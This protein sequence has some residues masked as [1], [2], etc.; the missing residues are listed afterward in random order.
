[1][2]P[3]SEA[4]RIL[5][6]GVLQVVHAVLTAVTVVLLARLLS[7]EVFGLYVYY[8]TLAALLPLLMGMG[9]EHVLVMHGSRS[10]S[11]VPLLFG[12]ALLVR[13][14]AMAITVVG[15]LLYIF[16][17]ASTHAFAIALIFVGGAL[18]VFPNPLF[19]SV[20][21]V[22]G[23]HVRPWLLNLT[24]SGGFVLYLILLP[25]SMMSLTSV[26]V[27]YCLVQG[28]SAIVLY[29]DVSRHVPPIIERRRLRQHSRLGL[30]FA[31]SQA[32]DYAMARLDVFAVQLFV[33]PS[34]LGLY[35][36]AQRIIG[37]LQIIPTSIHLTSLPDF[38]R[39]AHDDS[40]LVARFRAIRGLLL[41]VSVLV[42]GGLILLAPEIIAVIFGDGY[43]GA[44]AVLRWLAV[45]NVLVFLNYPYYM[46]AEAINRVE[47]RLVAKIVAMLVTI[48]AMVALIP[49]L[50][51]EG[52]AVSL[53]VGNAVF[54]GA[55]HIITRSR[56][57]RLW[58]LLLDARAVAVAAAGCLLA[59]AVT[60]FGNDESWLPIVAGAVY[61]VV[62]IGLGLL[63]K[64]TG[65][66][67][68]ATLL[69][70]LVRR[71]A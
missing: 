58:G 33:G 70:P 19:L 49:R 43:R 71:S 56:A 44:E 25:W 66:R 31:S 64:L 61:L 13:M 52:A 48:A 42:G 16:F 54:V 63:C 55:L 51:I 24:S 60:C 69:M 23:M 46:L 65:L 6:V 1:M 68:L 39:S 45:A 2:R 62:V 35:A 20:Y 27:G 4:H 67:L 15:A 5:A 14:V 21:R 11:T 30:S 59:F 41:D 12:N 26:A 8:S 34:A 50:G 40:V 10:E 47:A 7:S 3:T 28:V 29:C 38:H 22:H 18:A 32:L 57:G 9:V 17:S 37:V 53:V 36:A